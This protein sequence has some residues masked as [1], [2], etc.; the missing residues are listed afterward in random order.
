MNLIFFLADLWFNRLLLNECCIDLVIATQT[1]L[2]Q[3]LQ[4]V[5]SENLKLSLGIFNH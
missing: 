3:S 1:L 4:F 5:Y 2:A